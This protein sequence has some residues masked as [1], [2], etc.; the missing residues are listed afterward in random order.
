MVQEQD[1]P[2]LGTNKMVAG[3]FVQSE[4]VVT[5]AYVPN[6]TAAQAILYSSVEISTQRKSSNP[7]GNCPDGGQWGKVAKTGSDDL[8]IVCL[9]CLAAGPFGLFLLCCPIGEKDVYNY[10][11]KFYDAS[12]VC[13]NKNYRKF[14][15]SRTPPPT[16][17]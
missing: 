16:N 15:P 4:Q 13:L 8:C 2:T 11:G 9:G 14:I 7:P 3:D 12:G 17:R 1:S 10:D 5:N 6:N